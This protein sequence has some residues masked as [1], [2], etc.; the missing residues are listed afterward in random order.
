MQYKERE[1]RT[2]N[3]QWTLTRETSS[4]KLKVDIDPC[5]FLSVSKFISNV[6]CVTYVKL[7]LMDVCH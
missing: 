2:S 5:F 1:V 4:V 6:S 7:E 3:K